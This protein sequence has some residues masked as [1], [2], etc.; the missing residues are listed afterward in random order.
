MVKELSKPCFVEN[1]GLVNYLFR[2][3]W[4][5]GFSN[6]VLLKVWEEL[7]KMLHQLPLIILDFHHFQM[8][9]MCIWNLAM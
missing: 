3:Q 6:F 7:M 1:V 4:L 2:F 8:L 9:R 5:K